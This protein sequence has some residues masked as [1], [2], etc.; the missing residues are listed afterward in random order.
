MAATTVYR[1][2]GKV[3]ETCTYGH[4]HEVHYVEVKR[5]TPT[6]ATRLHDNGYEKMHTDLLVD[7]QGRVYHKHVTIDFFDNVS[8][9]R[10]NDGTRY[11]PLHRL[12]KTAA[13]D[14]TGRGLHGTP[15]GPAWT[16][17]GARR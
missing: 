12:S 5:L 13:R 15:D 17:P 16:G 2:R 9:V 1:V 8:Y 11:S 6:G 4:P 7:A 3:T 10:D 14:L